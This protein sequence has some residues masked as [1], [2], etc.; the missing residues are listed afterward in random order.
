MEEQRDSEPEEED[1]PI[2][3]EEEENESP[4][5]RLRQFSYE[6]KQEIVAEALRYPRNKTR[7]AEKYNLC[8]SQIT[9]WKKAIDKINENVPD[10]SERNKA[11]KKKRFGSGRPSKLTAAEDEQLFTYFEQL[12]EKGTVITTEAL[13][14]E[15][16]RIKYGANRRYGRNTMTHRAAMGRTYRWQA[17]RGIVLRHATSIQN[18][19]YDPN[20]SNAFVAEVNA[21]LQEESIPLDCA[22]NIDETNLYYDMTSTVTLARRGLRNVRIRKSKGNSRCT[23]LLGA[24][25]D[26]TKLPPFIIFIGKA[27][28]NIERTCNQS[29][30]Y[31]QDCRYCAQASGWVDQRNFNLWIDTVWAQFC[32]GKPK[33]L[34]I[35][36]CFSVHMMDGIRQKLEAMGTKVLIIPK[37]YTGKLQVLDVGINR[38]FKH[39]CRKEFQNFRL[40][41]S[42]AKP[43]HL[44]LARWISTAFQAI[45]V[46][47][48]KNTWRHIGFRHPTNVDEEEDGDSSDSSYSD[49]ESDGM[50]FEEASINGNSEISSDN[51]NDND[52][53]DD[54]NED[55]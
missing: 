34:L 41:D 10:E 33:T 18:Q 20:V 42:N 54:N 28:A 31:P 26:G 21:T 11:L 38:P 7:T 29:P 16:F 43:K 23:V 17:R 13:A 44:D 46:R 30:L 19:E 24:A 2:M 27:G 25:M 53:D 22:V 3:E 8:T 49:Y 35:M 37:G 32:V 36:D 51:D 5:K 50:T 1:E 9:R 47:T 52:D 40:A 48:I 14:G 12:E 39:Y 55:A 15:M 6:R 4:K 45:K